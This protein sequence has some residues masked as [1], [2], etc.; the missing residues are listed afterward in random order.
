MYTT[1]YTVIILMAVS[2]IVY[3][4]QPSVQVLTREPNPFNE[5]VSL[6]WCNKLRFY[7]KKL[8]QLWKLNKA[9]KMNIHVLDRFDEIY[10]DLNQVTIED[11]YIKNRD[12]T[13]IEFNSIN[14]KNSKPRDMSFHG[15]HPTNPLL[16]WHPAMRQQLI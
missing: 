16:R 6:N 14:F 5:V 9:N 15:K 12:Q 10:Y 4:P 2:T 8:A 1:K 11:V 13:R 7:N 3:S